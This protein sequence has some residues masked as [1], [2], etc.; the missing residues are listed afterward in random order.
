M[1]DTAGNNVVN[2]DE[3]DQLRRGL[4]TELGAR[5]LREIRDSSVARLKRYLAC[6][7]AHIDDTLFER[8][9]KSECEPIQ[10]QYLAAMQEL[11]HLRTDITDKFINGFLSRFNQGVS[12]QA[13]IAKD[14]WSIGLSISNIASRVR[15]EHTETLVALD[16]RIGF[17]VQDPDL[18]EWQNPLSPEVLCDAYREATLCIHSGVE[19]RLIMFRLFDQHVISQLDELYRA[20]NRQL[21]DFG[22]LADNEAAK[23]QPVLPPVMTPG[24]SYAQPHASAP[25]KSSASAPRKSASASGD[26]ADEETETRFAIQALTLL[27]QGGV[28]PDNVTIASNALASGKANILYKLIDSPLLQSLGSNGSTTVHIVAMMF[29]YI[30]NDNSIEEA[31]RSQIGRLQ[32]PVLKVALLDQTFLTRKSHPARQLLNRLVSAASGW[33][34]QQ[35][36]RNHLFRKINTTV[37]TLIND[38]ENDVALFKSVLADFEAFISMQEARTEERAKRSVTVAAGEEKLDAAKADALKEITLHVEN[39]DHQSFVSEFVSSHWKN[40]LFI[41]CA[42]QG[43]GSD[44]WQQAIATM[45]DLIWSVREKHTENDRKRLQAMQ[46]TLLNNLRIGMERMSIHATERDQFFARLAQAHA[47]ALVDIEDPETRHVPAADSQTEELAH[48]TAQDPSEPAV[49]RPRASFRIKQRAEKEV[50]AMTRGIWVRFQ[51]ADN[52]SLHAKLSWVSPITNSYLFTTRQ[53]LNAGNYSREELVQLINTDRARILG[54]TPP[55][56]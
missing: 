3:Y 44:A 31:V 47:L 8:S 12:R 10:R 6:M 39:V 20:T 53:G 5:A 49:P 16:R 40:L 32:I 36:D 23:I 15:D 4:S 19:I 29:D 17:L 50:D 38:F 46:P 30:L 42:R 33:S 55:L 48:S 34:E 28:L 1:K 18:L 25:E 56:D 22:V 51:Q 43:K 45:E 11:G 26:E 24:A 35:D 13:S 37:Q 52:Q 2:L 21:V 14:D 41:I 7:M 9:Q 27:Q 54:R